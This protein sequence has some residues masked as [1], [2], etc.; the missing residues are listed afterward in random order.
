MIPSNPIN[1]NPIS[2]NDVK[3]G[4]WVIA[5]YEN[6]KWLG[7]VVS[8]KANQIC[9][10]CLEKPYGVR[11][12]QNLEREEDAIYFDQVYHTDVVPTLSQIDMSGKKGRKWYWRY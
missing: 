10:H 11:E 9:V 3:I 6:E 1:L 5:I 7:K 4:I 2:Y 8:K 12:P